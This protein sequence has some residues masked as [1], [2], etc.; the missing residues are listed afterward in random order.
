MRRQTFVSL[1]SFL[2]CLHAVI[3]FSAEEDKGPQPI[4]WI[5]VKADVL[6]MTLKP[7]AR[8]DKS[9][10]L[11]YGTLAPVFKITEKNGMKWAQIRI[12]NLS[13]ARPQVGWVESDRAEILP[14]D[15]YPSDADLLGRLG[16][17]YVDDFTARHT[18]V[19]RFL[20]RQEQSAPLL[21]CYVFAGPLPTAKLVA[22]TASQGR[23]VPGAS[24][25]FPISEMHAGITGLE[26][27][28][29]LGDGNECVISREPFRAGPE[30]RGL[31]LVIRRIEGDKFRILWQAPVEFR[32]LAE[33]RSKVEILQPPE[34][35]I[36]APG[37]T[38]TGEVTFRQTG[39]Q[40]EP[41]WKGKVEFF[42]FGR[43]KPVDSVSVEKACPWDGKEFAPLR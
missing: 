17:P 13:T 31:H 14:A 11:T 28:D 35:N 7:G 23:Y 30:T 9:E 10:H 4:G 33:F 5:Y 3:A 24:L 25:D 41:V 6:D 21:L 20:V 18:D 34:K 27:R 32:N 42:L 12:L 2:V 22:F 15:S 40:Q 8:K 39:N 19:A 38:T 36:G 37:T 43:E 26:I 29:L 16:E 1:L